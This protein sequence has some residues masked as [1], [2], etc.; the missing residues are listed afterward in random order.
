MMGYI[1][2]T[3][4]NDG[5]TFCGR[6]S[7]LET[8]GELGFGHGYPYAKELGM[9]VKGGKGACGGY[10]LLSFFWGGG[11]VSALS[12]RTPWSVL[13][14]VLYYLSLSAAL[15]SLAMREQNQEMTSEYERYF[16]YERRRKKKSDF[17]PSRSAV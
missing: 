3:Y 14:L 11:I 12:G 6:L 5:A 15:L 10:F 7:G 13:L 9:G 17:I 4:I 16:E 8:Y 2:D 1:K